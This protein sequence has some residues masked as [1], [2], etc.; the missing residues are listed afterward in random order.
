[1]WISVQRIFDT[2]S[3]ILFLKVFIFLCLLHQ[4]C[5]GHSKASVN[6]SCS[7]SQCGGAGCRDNQGKLVC[8]GEGCNGTVSASLAALNHA[9]NV[10]ESLTVANKELQNVARKVWWER[11][12]FSAITGQ[13]LSL[14]LTSWFPVHSSRISPLWRRMWRTR[15]W[16]PWTKPR[17]RRTT[18]KTTTRS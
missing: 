16:T 9:R 4:V 6:G 2:L 8:G 11:L 7:D 10:S 14:D 5:G 17:R 15:P 3:T 12:L 1:M 18:L 13:R